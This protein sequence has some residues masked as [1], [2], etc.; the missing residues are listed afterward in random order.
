MTANSP[1]MRLASRFGFLLALAAL[2]ACGGGGG[3]GAAP[4]PP[5]PPP[6]AGFTSSPGTLDATFTAGDSVSV[7]I[8]LMP[9]STLASPPVFQVAD[10][11]GVVGTI[12]TTFA[13]SDGSFL[14]FLLT[15]ETVTAG[16]HTGSIQ[17]NA[18]TD[19]S[20][21]SQYSGSPVRIPFHFVVSAPVLTVALN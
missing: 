2:N 18:C 8:T 15:L 21:T 4:Q 16:T 3:G 19:S 11:G 10:S 6:P 5:P 9:P 17:L 7:S 14:V 20:C 1:K 13:N 12:V